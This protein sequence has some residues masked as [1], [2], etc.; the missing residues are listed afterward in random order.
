MISQFNLELPYYT[1]KPLDQA[2]EWVAFP[3]FIESKG[4]EYHSTLTAAKE[5]ISKLESLIDALSSEHCEF[6]YSPPEKSKYDLNTI[7]EFRKINNDC[8]THVYH[9]T[10]LS[11]KENLNLWEKMEA[12]TTVLDRVS[13]F[14]NTYKSDKQNDIQVGIRFRGK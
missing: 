11:F 8:M 6:S 9:Y 2:T 12:I 4:K 10:F 5:I 13:T 14:S 7:I 3:V 1:E